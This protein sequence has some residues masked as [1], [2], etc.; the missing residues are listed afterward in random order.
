MEEYIAQRDLLSA[1]HI[2]LLTVDMNSQNAETG[3]YEKLA[4]EVIA[5]KRARA[6][7]LLTRLREREQPEAL[8]DALMNE[9]ARTAESPPTRTASCLRRRDGARNLRPRSGP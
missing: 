5:E 4:D 2:L 6:E 3:E 1:K 7:E 9:Y 8:F